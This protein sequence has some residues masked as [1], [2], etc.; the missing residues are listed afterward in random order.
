MQARCFVSGTLTLCQKM[1]HG[2]DGPLPFLSFSALSATRIMEISTYKHPSV[3]F[4]R[5]RR[6]Y[7]QTDKMMTHRTSHV[8]PGSV[9]SSGDGP[10]PSSRC[11][12]RCRSPFAPDR[13]LAA[14]FGLNS[15]HRA[16][17]L[18]IF[19]LARYWHASEAEKSIFCNSFLSID[20][21]RN[22]LQSNG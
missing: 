5:P 6:Q 13:C 21:D 20:K 3:T 4:L 15:G 8:F 11:R 2:S 1:S 12:R 14:P 7:C 19:Q 10:I 9:N 22:C 18:R 17:T 16:V